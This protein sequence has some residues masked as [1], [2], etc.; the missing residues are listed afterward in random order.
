MHAPQRIPPT[1]TRSG[2]LLGLLVALLA[3][4]TRAQHVPEFAVHP[5]YTLQQWTVLDGLPVNAVRDILQTSDGYLW[6]A[7]NGSPL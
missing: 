6:L 5:D 2:L 1:A 3:P 7:T 4:T